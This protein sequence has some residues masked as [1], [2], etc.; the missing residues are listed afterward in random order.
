[1]HLDDKIAGHIHT[2]RHDWRDECGKHEFQPCPSSS[3]DV[4][5]WASEPVTNKTKPNEI[6][7]FNHPYDWRWIQ[8]LTSSEQQQNHREQRLLPLVLPVNKVEVSWKWCRWVV[9]LCRWV[10]IYFLLKGETSKRICRSRMGHFLT[11]AKLSKSVL[12]Y[13]EAIVMCLWIDGC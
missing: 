3:L 11:R 1:M 2:C 13:K 5:S 8:I 12:S 6:K 7:G 9:C 10:I 4:G